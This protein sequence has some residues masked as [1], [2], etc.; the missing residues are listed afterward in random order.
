M[1]LVAWLCTTHGSFSTYC[2]RSWGQI[3]ANERRRYIPY[4]THSCIGWDIA[5]VI[6][7]CD[8]AQKMD[9]GA[10]AIIYPSEKHLKLTQIPRNFVRPWHP[11]QLPGRFDIWHRARQCH[12]G[13]L[14]E[15]SK[16]L[17]N[18]E[19]SYAQTRFYEIWDKDGFRWDGWLL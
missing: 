10:V 19:I 6:W 3:S 2:L 12:W 18:C 16:R 13:D 7:I 14:C 17:A 11:L 5:H 1:F 4:V 8:N 15:M 9:P